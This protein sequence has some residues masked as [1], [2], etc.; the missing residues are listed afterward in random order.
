MH[1]S[2]LYCIG[3]RGAMGHEP[4]N[5]LRSVRKALELGVDAIEVDVFWV[6]GELLVFHDERLERTTNGEGYIWDKSF[7]ELRQLDAGQG[8]QIPTLQEVI[9]TIDRHALLNI[10]L[11][12]PNTAKPVVSLIA[13]FRKRGWNEQH[14]LVSSFYHPELGTVRELDPTLRL[15]VLMCGIP[16]DY[17]ACA[18]AVDAYSIHPALE[19][20]NRKLVE[21]AH[22]R[23][24]KVYVYTVNNR[25]DIERV[26]NLGA[27]GV[28]TNY[29]ELLCGKLEKNG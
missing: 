1:T 8:E 24:L 28:F 12:G 4:E 10:E 16:L 7:A 2:Q 13:Q 23:G 19:F 9:E 22:T 25:E 15:G 20:L 18:Q 27:D 14:F 11:K 26:R 21:D 29:P 3:H 5:T 6:D 17:A